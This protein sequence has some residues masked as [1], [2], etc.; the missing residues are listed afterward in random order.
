MMMF[1]RYGHAEFPFIQSLD[2]FY[3]LQRNSGYIC[4][5]YLREPDERSSSVTMEVSTIRMV[6]RIASNPPLFAWAEC[7]ILKVTGDKSRFAMI[8]PVL[9]KYL[10][11][12]NR[13]GDPE[14]LAGTS[15]WNKDDARQGH[16][17]Q[18][19]WNTAPRQRNG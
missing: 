13:D 14:G 19:Y 1:A 2:N 8:L 9:E 10:E 11:F 15:G 18:L 7:E 3:C 5:E 12:L 17:H 4:R 16:P 6:G